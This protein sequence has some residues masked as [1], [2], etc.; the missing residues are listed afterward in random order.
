[1][2]A[3][4]VNWKIVGV[5]G[6]D[7]KNQLIVKKHFEENLLF[8]RLFWFRKNDLSLHMGFWDENTKSLSEALLNENKIIAKSLNISKEDTVL[9][10]GC[11]VGGTAIWIAEKYGVNVVGVDLVEQNIK[12]AKKYAKDRKVSHLVEF[13]TNDFFDQVFGNG[14]FTKIY[15]IESFCYVKN[16]DEFIK[17]VFKIL[18]LGGKMIIADYFEGEKITDKNHLLLDKWTTEWAMPKLLNPGEMAGLSNALGFNKI[19]INDKTLQMVPSSNKLR[20]I[21]LI[22][23][24][25][26]KFLHTLKLISDHPSKDVVKS[27]SKLFSDRAITYLTVMMEK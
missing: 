16:K 25:L 10:I 13:Y 11:G 17:K 20:R 15:C 12:L 2:A 23:Y 26:L 5:M 1:M 4:F 18:R 9:D 19:E 27:E 7:K 6:G 14:V 3:I 22:T 21:S 8:S 24:P